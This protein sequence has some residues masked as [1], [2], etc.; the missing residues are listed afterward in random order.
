MKAYTGFMA[1]LND[2]EAA[3]QSLFVGS[4]VIVYIASVRAVARIISVNPPPSQF[5]QRERKDS[6][7]IFRFN[8]EDE[9]QKDEEVS[10]RVG[11][12]R[13]F[14]FEFLGVGWMEKGA[15]VLVMKNQGHSGMEVFV[16]TVVNRFR[17][18]GV[19]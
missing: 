19:I 13:R 7:N 2:D 4:D 8:D 17:E 10:L 18:V 14:G 6:T 1:E 9:G 15:K 5:T 12:K 11:C 16:G 3:A